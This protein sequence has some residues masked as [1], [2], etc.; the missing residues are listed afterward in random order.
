MI[1][2]FAFALAQAIAAPP[3]IVVTGKS[4][5]K[6]YAECI[7]GG[8]TPLR[9]AQISIAWAEKLF[10]D[11][12]YMK[13]KV[14]L[15]KAVDRNSR[16]ARSD[17]RP[18]AAIYE[19]YATVALHEGDKDVYRRA[20]SNQV[21]TLRDNLPAD[22]PAVTDT[23]L[24]LGDMWVKLQSPRDADAAYQAAERKAREQG[25][26]NI[27]LSAA[28]RRVWL[29]SSMDQHDRAAHLLEEIARDPIAQD[30][31]IQA[32]LPAL[33][34]RL[35]IRNSNDAEITRAVDT[36]GGK[37]TADKPVLVWAPPYEQGADAAAQDS[38]RRLGVFDPTDTRSTD[39]DPIKWADV[40][41][42][43]RPDGHTDEVEI[44]RGSPA[45]AWA[46]PVL[47]QI[48]ARRYARLNEDSAAPGVY[49]IE[50]FTMRATYM[51]PKGSLIRRRAGPGRLEI[52]DLTDAST[53]PPKAN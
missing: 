23:A 53:R 32:I 25:Q 8:C 17:P 44:L 28:L 52:V 39:N 11:G 45:R 5:D 21:Q 38:A 27:A 46:N 47:N 37:G 7:A 30:P 29:A 1:A 13:A 14:S 34:L 43:V 20:V 9:D 33:R 48:T 26:T 42:W 24:A 22:D 50:R 51:V 41:F 49:R 2:L 4:L 3:Q 12:D 31:A 6:A 36:L 18:V 15:S 35:A 40:G 19:A 16:F 10:R